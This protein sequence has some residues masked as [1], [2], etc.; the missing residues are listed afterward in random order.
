MPDLPDIRSI[1]GPVPAAAP[2]A[3][4]IAA[5]PT[6]GQ[7]RHAAAQTVAVVVGFDGDLAV[8]EA[9]GRWLGIEGLPRMPPGA[10]VRLA[11]PA[12]FPSIGGSVEVRIWSGIG[13]G[14]PSAV[15]SARL[16]TSNGLSWPAELRRPEG[17]GSLSARILGDGHSAAAA[18]APSQAG[19]GSVA[20]SILLEAGIVDVTADGSCLLATP[21]GEW[22]MSTAMPGLA[23]GRRLKLLLTHGSAAAADTATSRVG[24]V[25]DR[26][27]LR[28]A[29]VGL[30]ALVARFSPHGEGAA[31]DI[32]PPHAAREHRAG[33]AD[34]HARPM[35][36]E[37][38]GDGLDWL[39]VP[40]RPPWDDAARV[41][42]ARERDARPGQGERAAY[43]RMVLALA[44]SRLGEVQLDLGFGEDGID[45]AVRTAG[46]LDDETARDIRAVLASI[47]AAG[48]AL[49]G[50]L[51]ERLL[52]L[53]SR[54]EARDL[55][56]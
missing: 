22:L 19:A 56:A 53:P 5:R 14:E 21:D 17:G 12:G 41:L 43:R 9:G 35:E 11:L 52:V 55:L 45:L 16:V 49:Q 31:G 23:A 10:S 39:V 47:A 15:L 20:G 33:A 36:G 46:P 27:A 4:E 18:H 6:A 1:A 24:G 44:L 34:E 54:R 3:G 26:P 42:L 13:A 32:A 28:D 50:R 38:A 7:L 8:V 2:G 40:E 30:A 51:V 29:A 48:H 37:P 25:P